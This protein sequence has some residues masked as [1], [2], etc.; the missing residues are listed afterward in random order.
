MSAMSKGN[1]CEFGQPFNEGLSAKATTPKNAQRIRVQKLKNGK[2]G[3]TVTV[4]TGL[5]LDEA[6]LRA[7]LKSFK[8][9]CGTGG[10]LKGDRL[11]LQGDQVKILLEV[12][13]DDGYR[14]KRA[15][16]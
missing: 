4:V 12:L 13:H 16:G 15:G 7:L 14:P 9:R 11:E 2:G 3:K 1:W 5:E 10:T 6:A 8:S